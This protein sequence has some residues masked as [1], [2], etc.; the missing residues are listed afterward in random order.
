MRFAKFSI[1]MNIFR[2]KLDKSY[3]SERK[4]VLGHTYLLLLRKVFN[5]CW[6]FIFYCSARIQ[7][8]PLYD[9]IIKGSL[10]GYCGTLNIMN[11]KACASKPAKEKIA[12]IKRKAKECIGSRK[13]ANNII[14]LLCFS[15]VIPELYCRSNTQSIKIYSVRN[16]KHQPH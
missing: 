15:Q 7:Q 5:I 10:I 6:Q 9:S 8:W 11:P 16:W 1:I 13:G 2:L 12:E 4:F 3:F 14:D